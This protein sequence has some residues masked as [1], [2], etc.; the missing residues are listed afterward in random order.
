MQRW[1]RPSR[2]DSVPIGTSA[3]RLQLPPFE[4][5]TEFEPG[6]VCVTG[7]CQT[8]AGH[9]F[10][11]PAAYR[12][13]LLH[14]LCMCSCYIP[15]SWFCRHSTTS[16]QS[17]GTPNNERIGSGCCSWPRQGWPGL[18]PRTPDRFRISI[19]CTVPRCTEFNPTETSTPYDQ[20]AD[21]CGL[22]L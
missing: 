12:C 1:S 5:R 11:A 15:P 17:R 19:G 7:L 18:I 10:V 14:L 4:E 9:F 20:R 3:V 21:R 6:S 8:N 22:V 2:S 13:S 16:A